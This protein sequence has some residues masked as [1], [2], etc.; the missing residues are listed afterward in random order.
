M[1]VPTRLIAALGEDDHGRF[2]HDET[3]ARG[4]DCSST[5]MVRSPRHRTR[6]SSYVSLLRADGE[7]LAGV[8][9]MDIMEAVGAAALEARRDLIR[10]AAVV[11]AD[12]NLSEAALAILCDLARSLF[13]DRVSEVEALRIPK[14]PASVHTLK[15]N[16]AEAAALRV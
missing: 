16:R 3:V 4:A 12:R 14:F 8:N 5:S 11:V 1:D 15:P 10:H 7:L 9:H 13:V 2:V 6:Q